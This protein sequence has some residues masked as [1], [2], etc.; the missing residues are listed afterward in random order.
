MDERDLLNEVRNLRDVVAGTQPPAVNRYWPVTLSWGCVVTAGYLTCGF[1]GMAGK[2]ALLAWVWPVLAFLVAWPLHWYLSRGVRSRIEEGGVRPRFRKDLMWPWIAI[3]GMGLLWTAG[4]GIS[5]TMA[6]HW[7]VLS[8]AWGSLLF[9]GYV[10]NGVPLSKEWLWAAA[11]LLA[12]L[13]AA[14]LAGPGFYWLPGL[15]IGG[16]FLLA[17]LLGRRNE[18]RQVAQ[19]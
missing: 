12:S 1:L 9:V 5:G 10:V 6:S 17:G 11:V 16:T 3:A 8:F 2:T 14:F 4:L 18:R 7:Y 15:W 13:I 19:A